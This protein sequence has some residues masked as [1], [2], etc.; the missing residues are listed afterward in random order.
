MHF[1]SQNLKVNL[2]NNNVTYIDLKTLEDWAIKSRVRPVTISIENNPM[3]CD[4][5]LYDFLR[6][7]EGRLHSNV[8]NTLQLLIG[9][10]KCHSPSDSRKIAITD[11]RSKTLKYNV[12]KRDFG[13][14]CPE[15]NNC[16]MHPENNTF[17]VEC[18]YKG[19]IKAPRKIDCP[20]NHQI[21]HIELNMTGNYLTKMP[22]LDQN[23]YNN[24]TV[25]T[26][27]HNKIWSVTLMD[28]PINLR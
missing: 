8:N 21:D 5:R 12:N 27:N 16:Y 4:L 19:V 9:K 18:G 14:E 15:K 23:G 20:L 10:S 24:V 6:Y 2:D 17:I 11:S 7:L 22:V 28:F 3:R 25:L 1:S 26:L 13:V